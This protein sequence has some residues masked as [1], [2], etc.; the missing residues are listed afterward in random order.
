MR[1]GFWLRLQPNVETIQIAMSTAANNNDAKTNTG[2]SKSDNTTTNKNNSLLH[3]AD[4]LAENREWT[5]DFAL[6]I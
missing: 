1:S 5:R 6:Y 3:E 4:E 2:S